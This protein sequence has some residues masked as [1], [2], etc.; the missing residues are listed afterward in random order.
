MWM[1]ASHNFERGL[2]PSPAWWRDM[3]GGGRSGL[4]HTSLHPSPWSQSLLEPF[5]RRNWTSS[6]SHRLLYLA[7]DL[8]KKQCVLLWSEAW[9][10]NFLFVGLLHQQPPAKWPEPIWL[11][12]LT[13]L[14]SLVFSLFG[15]SLGAP[16]HPHTS[17]A[18]D[19]NSS[20][21][22]DL[23]SGLETHF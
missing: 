2:I 15:L 6:A 16:I 11:T 1:L 19:P 13:G 22:S 23:S 14:G 3:A 20:S 21:S 10:S 4:K 7:D 17:S 18:R 8:K 12:L 5:V 9:L